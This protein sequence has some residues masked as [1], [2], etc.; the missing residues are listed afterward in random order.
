VTVAWASTSAAG[1]ST[2]AVHTSC[3]CG[4]NAGAAA[5]A[6]G[7]SAGSTFSGGR[8]DPPDAVNKMSQVLGPG[9][10]DAWA[11]RHGNIP[12]QQ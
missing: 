4:H 12:R 1:R 8:L 7:A 10:L 6:V 9:I 11:E 2:C 5:S 3:V